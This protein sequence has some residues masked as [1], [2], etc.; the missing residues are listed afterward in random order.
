MRPFK[1]SRLAIGVAVV[2]A[3]AASTLAIGSIGGAGAQG[4]VRGFDGSTVTVASM[5]IAAQFVPGV[6]NGVQARI[7]R[8]NDDNEIKGVQIDW[9][10]FADVAQDPA[11]SLNEARRLVTQSRVFA[12]VGDTS[13]ANPGDF[14][15]QQKVPYFGWAFDNTYC[16][17]KPS[18]KLYGFGYNGC[19]V[20]SDPSVMGDG[21]FLNY[22]YV[23]EKTGKKNPT[24]ALFSNDSQSGKNAVKFQQLTYKGAGYKIVATNNQMPLPPVADYAPYAQA[25]L[26][27]D[28]GKQ[29]DAVACLLATDC[30]QMFSLMKANGYTGTYISSLYSN[31]LL[32]AMD[33]SGANVPVVPLDATTDNAGLEQM[34]ED[35]D[36][37]SP[38]ASNRIDTATIAG[39]ASTD[40]FIQALKTVAKKGKSNITPENVQKAAA[41]QTWQIEG[42]AGPTTFPQSTVTPFPACTAFTIS[43]GTTW[44]TVE[45]FQCSEKQY[46][47]K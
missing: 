25:M 20:P 38:G 14:F 43:D 3:L 45:P 17:N 21:A 23:S 37:F 28:N 12:I 2:A 18:T 24:L 42:L 33:G 19:L 26:T 32:K 47:V 31:I 10:E 44:N 5:G 9:T 1:R 41:K 30:I 29:P 27:A 11:T 15:T 8:F 35:L 40:M 34:K 6:P 7:K 16:S 39:Y 4:S 36:D 46:K 22:K 13:Q